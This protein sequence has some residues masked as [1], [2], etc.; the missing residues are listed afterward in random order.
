M[1]PIG[2]SCGDHFKTYFRRTQSH[3]RQVLG[4]VDLHTT[5]LHLPVERL[6]R[7]AEPITERA[8]ALAQPSASPKVSCQLDEAVAGLQ[9]SLL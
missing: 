7:G 1:R 8:V 9:G 3:P 6:P 5:E 4:L 2:E